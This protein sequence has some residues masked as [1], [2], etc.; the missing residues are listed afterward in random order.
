MQGTWEAF[1]Y[2]YYLN[3]SPE[4]TAAVWKEVLSVP[5]QELHPHLCGGEDASSAD[6]D[7]AP[8]PLHSWICITWDK[9][10]FQTLLSDQFFSLFVFQEQ[11]SV[12]SDPILAVENVRYQS[13]LEINFIVL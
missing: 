1:G 10:P 8:V 11:L 6:L 13:L 7:Q 5:P 2:H 12:S 3:H 4:L 9:F